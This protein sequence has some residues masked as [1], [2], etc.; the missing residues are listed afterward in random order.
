RPVR[1][2]HAGPDVAA[3]VSPLWRV[4]PVRPAHLAPAEP[5]AELFRAGV[6][7]RKRRPQADPYAPARPATAAHQPQRHADPAGAA[8]GTGPDDQPD[9]AGLGAGTLGGPSGPAILAGGSHRAI[10]PRAAGVLVSGH[11]ADG[12]LVRLLRFRAVP[13]QAHLAG[14]LGPGTG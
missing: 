1:R 8:P 6:P 13:E 11:G 12:T 5:V 10:W 14:R 7:A 2:T 3:A 4:L 9:D